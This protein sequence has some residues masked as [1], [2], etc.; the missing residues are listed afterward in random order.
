MCIY[1]DYTW[2]LMLIFASIVDTPL[3][4]SDQIHVTSFISPVTSLSPKHTHMHRRK[5]TQTDGHPLICSFSSWKT[6]QMTASSFGLV[7]VV[8][9]VA[10]VGG[11]TLIIPQNPSQMSPSLGGRWAEDPPPHTHTYP[12]HHGGA[13]SSSNLLGITFNSHA[14]PGT[15]GCGAAICLACCGIEWERG[16]SRRERVGLYL[17]V[18]VCVCDSMSGG[19]ARRTAYLPRGHVT[20]YCPAGPSL[21]WNTLDLRSTHTTLAIHVLCHHFVTH[22]NLYHLTNI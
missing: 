12:P 20:E 13:G 4:P 1:R 14:F 3:S 9:A 19:V 5:H 6:E 18:W 10:V 21:W 8:V 22:V 17:S 11:S 7:P 2:T 15:A 16:G